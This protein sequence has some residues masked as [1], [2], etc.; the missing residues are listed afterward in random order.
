V[1]GGEGK[2]V[3]VAPPL[4]PRRGLA[5][6]RSAARRHEVGS[7]RGWRWARRAGAALL[8][9]CFI[10]PFYW[11][12][13][14]SLSRPGEFASYPP[15]LLP[16]W[17][18]ANWSRAWAAAPWPRLFLNT[19]LVASCTVALCLLT[20]V[21][22]GF[23]FGVLRFRGRRFLMVLTLSVLMM[24]ATVLIIPDYVLASDLHWIDTYWVQIVPWG[25]SVFGIFLV[26]Q[27]FTTMPQELLD[28]A[29]LDGAGRLRVLR[30]IGLPMVRPALVIIAI[31][32]FMATWN[33]FLWPE[34]MTRSGT[35][36]STVQPVEVGLAAYA[37]TDGTDYSAL[38]AAATF[39]T[40][41][42]MV[43]FL[44]LQRQFIRGAL[45]AAGGLR[46]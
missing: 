44:V 38:A 34:I 19:I 20:S 25:A 23:A 26:R 28:A 1:R 40:L 15:V 36:S 18:W 21:L 41:P 7:K 9:L 17:D 43:F 16:H 39:T 22:A 27:F 45:S 42:V 11:T 4:A 13:V 12:V 29:A 35:G 14:V 30:H 33:S 46:G 32:V 10:V 3:T 31:N 2:R 6:R 8:G 37:G 24:P 5:S